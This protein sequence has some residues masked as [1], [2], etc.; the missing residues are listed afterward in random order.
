M[1]MDCAKTIESERLSVGFE[2][3]RRKE[4]SYEQTGMVRTLYLLIH[5]TDGNIR[6]RIWKG[7]E[8]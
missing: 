7:Q 4:V 8:S 5:D 1:L 3:I 2:P 6:L